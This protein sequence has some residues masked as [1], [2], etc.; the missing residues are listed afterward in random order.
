MEHTMNINTLVNTFVTRLVREL[1]NTTKAAPANDPH[2]L[3]LA[4]AQAFS[5][6]QS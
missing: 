1:T 6:T 5:R 4:Y 3:A 2:A